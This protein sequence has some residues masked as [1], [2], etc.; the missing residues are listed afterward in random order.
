MVVF[1][2]KFFNITVSSACLKGVPGVRGSDESFPKR[3]TFLMCVR[4]PL[5]FSV[6]LVALVPLTPS[7][8]HRH[9]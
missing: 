1:V 9:R 4:G 8:P 5:F 3:G 6:Q 2:F 7:H